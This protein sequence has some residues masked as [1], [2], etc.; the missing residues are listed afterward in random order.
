MNEEMKAELIKRNSEEFKAVRDFISE[1]EEAKDRKKKIRLYSLKPSDE[2]DERTLIS[3]AVIYDLEFEVLQFNLLDAKHKL[4]K[5]PKTGLY[6]FKS[7]S[8]SKYIELP[9]EIKAKLH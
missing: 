9:F 6:Y 4:F 2:L 1:H 5:D 7:S 8:G 3:S